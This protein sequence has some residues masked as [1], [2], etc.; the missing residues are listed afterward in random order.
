MLARLL[1]LFLLLLATPAW[2]Y[3]PAEPY[4]YA[5]TTPGGK[6]LLVVLAPRSVEA[7]TA[8]RRAD[9]AKEIRELRRKYPRAG[10]YPNDGS[11]EP[12]WTI[13]WYAFEGQLYLKDDGIHVIKCDTRSSLCFYV[14]GRAVRAYVLRDLMDDV[15]LTR[16]DGSGPPLLVQHAAL[17]GEF[18][19]TV[20]TVDGNVFTFDIRTGEILS[21][22]R[23]WGWLFH[24]LL[25]FGGFALLAL[26]VGLVARLLWFRRATPA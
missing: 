21:Q 7:E 3:K 19:F 18:E 26:A 13:D 25:A 6:Y 10:L 2:A 14:N 20:Q 16:N 24:G 22:P 23:P 4:S 12:L 9:D 11:V 1:S 15:P 8:H 17:T 5:C